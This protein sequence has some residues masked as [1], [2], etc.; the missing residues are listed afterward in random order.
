MKY[1][2]GYRQDSKWHYVKFATEEEMMEALYDII[3]WAERVTIVPINHI[4]LT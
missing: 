1:K 2:V 3:L 4:T